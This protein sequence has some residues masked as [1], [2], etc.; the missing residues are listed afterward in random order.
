AGF[1]HLAA[2]HG[3]AE[4]LVIV[5]LGGGLGGGFLPGLAQGDW[6]GGSETQGKEQPAKGDFHIRFLPKA[7]QAAI[8][9]RANAWTI[10][11]L[12]LAKRT[13]T[14]SSALPADWR[15]CGGVALSI[16]I[17]QSSRRYQPFPIVWILFATAT[18]K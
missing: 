12:P 17:F 10:S 18:R 11:A 7:D 3:K 9:Y 6:G 8:P 5:L 13:G 2:R 14:S 15:T 4:E 1:K 16:F